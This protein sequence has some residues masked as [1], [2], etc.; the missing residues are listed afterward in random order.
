M[1]NDNAISLQTLTEEERKVWL[2]ELAAGFA[3]KGAFKAYAGTLWDEASKKRAETQKATLITEATDLLQ[4]AMTQLAMFKQYN[5]EPEFPSD[6]ASMTLQ[7]MKDYSD[8]EREYKAKVQPM[9]DAVARANALLAAAEK[10]ET[11]KVPGQ[12]NKSEAVYVQGSEKVL[13]WYKANDNLIFARGNGFP[14]QIATELNIDN[15]KWYALKKNGAGYVVDGTL[16]LDKPAPSHSNLCEHISV[17]YLLQSDHPGKQGHVLD[18]E[19][20][21]AANTVS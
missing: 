14:A 17:E 10:G 16:S 19:T 12:R 15:S 2:H 18:A 3:S 1:T 9:A 13:S 20:W 6:I 7:A 4:S 5:A 21:F 8:A 11:P